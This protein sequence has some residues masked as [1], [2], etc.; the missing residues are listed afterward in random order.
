MDIGEKEN[1]LEEFIR[2][3][4]NE[5]CYEMS[6]DKNAFEMQKEFYKFVEIY[7]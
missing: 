1:R 5:L 3:L 6:C 4:S 7:N 2:K